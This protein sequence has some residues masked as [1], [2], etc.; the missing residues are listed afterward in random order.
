MALSKV[1]Q[2][3]L[4]LVMTWV[5]SLPASPR[6]LHDPYSHPPIPYEFRYGVRDQYY[7]TDFGHEEESNGASVRG[8]YYVLLPDGRR[9]V[10]TY[11]ADHQRGFIATVTY[12]NVGFRPQG[13]VAHG[14]T[15][16]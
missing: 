10:V 9:Q 6:L 1:R 13:P 3:L 12:E 7:G 11:T 15:Y 4:M 5:L 14:N 16:G 2:V 8:R